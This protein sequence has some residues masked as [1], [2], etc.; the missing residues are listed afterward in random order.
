MLSEV[1][2][3]PEHRFTPKST[4]TLFSST[5]FKLEMKKMSRQHARKALKEGWEFV[6]LR[7]IT[8]TKTRPK[9]AIMTALKREG[10][11]LQFLAANESKKL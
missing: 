9:N 7:V 1:Q 2:F 11:L 6:P 4:L 10:D 3:L 5:S 8:H